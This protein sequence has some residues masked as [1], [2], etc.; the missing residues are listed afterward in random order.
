M[1]IRKLGLAIAYDRVKLKL[2]TNLYAKHIIKSMNDRAAGVS[3]YQQEPDEP[4]EKA[5]QRFDSL[6]IPLTLCIDESLTSRATVGL[7]MR[8]TKLCEEVHSMQVLDKIIL[9]LHHLPPS[10]RL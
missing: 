10:L 9:Y 8:D 4:Y 1:I 6:K 3:I 2:V 7:R 5:L